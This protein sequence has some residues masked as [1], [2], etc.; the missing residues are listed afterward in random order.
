MSTRI[1]K[2]S[3]FEYSGQD[4]NRRIAYRNAERHREAGHDANPEIELERAGF[5]GAG[6]FQVPGIHQGIQTRP[7]PPAPARDEIGVRIDNTGESG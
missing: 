1:P 5:H 7:A 3:T 2:R 6:N 4:E